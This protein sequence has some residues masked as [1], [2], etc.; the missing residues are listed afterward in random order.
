MFICTI[1]EYIILKE[2]RDN[3][4]FALVL[5]VV[6]SMLFVIGVFYT[7]TAI[8]GNHIAIVDLITFFVATLIA[9]MI[10]YNVINKS[11]VSNRINSISLII[12]I[13][14]FLAFIIFTYNPIKV[15]LFRDN[16]NNTY[17]IFKEI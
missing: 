1:Y 17:G 9:Q 12:S 3:I 7:Y 11:N 4:F 15:D 13:V 14:I 10:W 6:I 5:K 16:S 8:V 2:K